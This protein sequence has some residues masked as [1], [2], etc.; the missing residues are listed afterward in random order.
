MPKAVKSQGIC[1]LE[2]NE[3]NM[4][5]STQNASKEKDG[6]TMVLIWG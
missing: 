1:S 3:G 2:R 6:R 5:M 4:K